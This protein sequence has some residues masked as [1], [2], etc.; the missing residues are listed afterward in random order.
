MELDFDKANK[1]GSKEIGLTWKVY[2][3]MVEGGCCGRL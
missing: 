1:K 2:D 3:K